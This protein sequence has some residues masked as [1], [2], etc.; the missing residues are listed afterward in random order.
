MSQSRRKSQRRPPP[1]HTQKQG[2]TPVARLKWYVPLIALAV[3]LIA[4]VSGLLFA[5]HLE[6]NDAFCASCHTQ[7]ESTYVQ[8]SQAAAVDLASAHVSLVQHTAGK[9]PARCIDCHSAPGA[10]G[11]VSAIA[12][13][14]QDAI[15]WV[16]GSA[17]QPAPQTVP[18]GDVTCLN[19][20]ADTPNATSFNEHFHRFLTRWQRADTHA[21]TCVSC[22]TAHTTDGD[23]SI[24][25]LQ[26]QRTV[27]V[28]QN[29]HRALGAGG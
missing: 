21:A 9:S 22:H 20:H 12:L 27:D 1:K 19:C 28:C 8:H 18:I 24:A 6:D 2:K 29:C 11:R 16:T 15:K 13:G 4:G 25:F 17:I 26:Q 10:L 7:P 23:S 14:A 5:A 3:C